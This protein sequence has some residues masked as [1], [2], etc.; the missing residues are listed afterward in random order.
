VDAPGT[1]GGPLVRVGGGPAGHDCPG[2]DL[3]RA[4]RGPAHSPH[5]RQAL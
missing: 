2:G 4:A 1:N 3:G 5:D